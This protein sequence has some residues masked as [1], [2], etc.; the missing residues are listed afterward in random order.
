MSGRKQVSKAKKFRSRWWSKLG[1]FISN[2][3]FHSFF[4]RE[5][6]VIVIE[7]RPLL[8]WHVDMFAEN[9]LGG[10]VKKNCALRE[11]FHG[12]CIGGLSCCLCAM[13]HKGCVSAYLAFLGTEVG[14]CRYGC[15]TS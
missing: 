2:A 4:R 14:N 13:N 12:L 11:G 10:L 9:S 5:P 7:V 1:N 6:K 3:K 15:N 8:S